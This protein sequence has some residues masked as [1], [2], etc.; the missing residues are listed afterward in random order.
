MWRRSAPVLLLAAVASCGGQK[1]PRLAQFPLTSSAFQDGR[2]IPAQFTCE[3]AARSPPLQW[4]SVPQGTKSLAL[5]LDD[6]DAPSGTFRHWA[7]YDIPASAR[8]VAAGQA[9]NSQAMNDFGQPGY[10]APCPPR[11]SA[12]HHYHFKLYA[13]GVDRLSLPANPKVADVEKE[14]GK[15]AVGRAELIGTYE[16]K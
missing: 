7:A 11:G 4:S 5:I 8:S 3:G 15:H 9:I 1:A 13:L 14:A 16:R 10:G 6:P 12:P 2:P